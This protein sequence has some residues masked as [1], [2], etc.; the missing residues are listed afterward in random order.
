MWILF[1]P[2][3]GLATPTAMFSSPVVGAASGPE[4]PRDAMTCTLADR[5][6]MRKYT[7]D[8]ADGRD[9]GSKL[10]DESCRLTKRAN[11]ADG[12]SQEHGS[13]PDA[14]VLI[15]S[16]ADGFT[17]DSDSSDV[18]EVPQVLKSEVCLFTAEHPM[19]S[20]NSENSSRQSEFR[21]LLRD[22]LT[23]L[24]SQDEQVR[25]MKLA[26]RML[27]RRF[28]DGRDG[29]SASG[30]GNDGTIT[31][32]GVANLTATAIIHATATPV[33]TYA[34]PPPNAGA[35]YI[36]PQATCSA[37]RSNTTVHS[38]QPSTVSTGAPASVTVSKEGGRVSAESLA[39]WERSDGCSNSGEQAV[40]VNMEMMDPKA[41]EDRGAYATASSETQC[42][43][44][45]S[46]TKRRRRVMKGQDKIA[47]ENSVLLDCATMGL[48]YDAQETLDKQAVHSAEVCED[49]SSASEAFVSTLA[50]ALVPKDEV[51]EG[52]LD[53]FPVSSRAE[54][55]HGEDI[56]KQYPHPGVSVVDVSMDHTGNQQQEET[57][58]VLSRSELMDPSD[59]QGAT[60]SCS[61]SR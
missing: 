5:M 37:A 40:S 9:N 43:M 1:S 53:S 22:G 35:S 52:K 45:G 12:S 41:P 50:Q 56:F 36:S 25:K 61:M 48:C 30:V 27:V 24:R 21:P 44:I 28:P 11:R 60:T 57:Q 6:L 58:E 29:W 10:R 7:V 39:G 4:L 42:S 14:E 46:D 19:V 15:T 38:T 13:S 18:A 55:F 59:K 17:E 26:D 34:H 32:I 23:Q 49:V 47:P 51:G 3:G 20:R 2:T 33:P 31:Q 8:V 54:K 16:R